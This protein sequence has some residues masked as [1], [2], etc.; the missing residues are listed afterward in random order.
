MRVAICLNGHV[1]TYDQTIDYFYKN[2]INSNNHHEIDV[3]I[4]TWHTKNTK[5]SYR[6]LNDHSFKKDIELTDYLDL[7]N[8]YKPKDIT[9]EYFDNNRYLTKNFINRNIIWDDELNSKKSEDITASRLTFDPITN[10]HVATCQTYTCYKSFCNTLNYGPYDCYIKFRFDTRIVKPLI[11]DNYNFNEDVMYGYIWSE[12]PHAQVD[13]CMGN[14]NVFKKYSECYLHLKE[15]YSDIN[16]K[17]IEDT[18][19]RYCQIKNIKFVQMKYLGSTND[20]RDVRL[21][22]YDIIR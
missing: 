10:I 17:N 12:S 3:F 8:L 19:T 11:L 2:I 1:R 18:F 15:I 4:H 16:L 7:Y 14:Y 5:I 13:F 9:V 20:D 22:G 21:T 6:N